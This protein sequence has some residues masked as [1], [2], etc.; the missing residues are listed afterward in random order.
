MRYMVC[1]LLCIHVLH[2]WEEFWNKVI[3]SFLCSMGSYIQQQRDPLSTECDVP[4][5]LQNLY[6]NQNNSSDSFIDKSEEMS[7]CTRKVVKARKVYVCKFCN[8]TFAYP[9][10]LDVHTRMIHTECRSLDCG[11]KLKKSSEQ[12]KVHDC[13]NCNKQTYGLFRNFSRCKNH[14]E[15]YSAQKIRCKSCGESYS[16]CYFSKVCCRGGRDM[17]KIDPKLRDLYFL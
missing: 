8:K 11:A 5:H 1:Q 2:A 16:R 14:V 4:M 6:V 10:Y 9:S 17:S 12:G 7:A 13:K 15:P 3:T